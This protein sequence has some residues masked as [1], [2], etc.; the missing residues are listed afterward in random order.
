[1]DLNF[2]EI[3]PFPTDIGLGGKFGGHEVFV[4]G[5]RTPQEAGLR[6]AKTIDGS[7]ECQIYEF[8]AH[9][10][11]TKL[12]IPPGEV[13]VAPGVTAKDANRGARGAD[14]PK[15]APVQIMVLVQTRILKPDGQG[16][17]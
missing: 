8:I 1:M 15:P 11:K 2:A 16:G 10:L 4:R 13:V 5:A 9:T 6:V 3:R 17:K 12:T 7:K 14:G